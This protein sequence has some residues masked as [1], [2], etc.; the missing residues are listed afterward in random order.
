MRVVANIGGY[1][2]VPLVQL[3]IWQEKCKV[4][5]HDHGIKGTLVLSH[6]GVNIMLAGEQRAITTFVSWFKNFPE[7]KTIQFKYARSDFVPFKRM[8][9]K[10]KPFLVPGLLPLTNRDKGLNLTPYEL[11]CWYEKSQDFVLID[12][13]NEYEIAWGK[14]ENAINMHLH[15]F[16]NFETALSNI[17]PTVKE[18]KVVFYCTGGIRCEKAVPVAKKAGFKYVYQLEGGILNYF[19][20]YK[21]AYYQG[22]CYVFDE[23]Q[24][25]TS[26]LEPIKK[27]VHTFFSVFVCAQ[28]KRIS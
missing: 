7:F 16:K 26:E 18:K 5:T 8:L 21:G 14:F 22:D 6:E 3:N 12:V 2:F 17:N 23:R 24:A 1:L 15:E 25:L 4:F 13:R 20:E 28:D 10:I 27:D 9:V 11:K 19:K